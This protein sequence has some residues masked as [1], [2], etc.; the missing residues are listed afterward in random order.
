M[1]IVIMRYMYC[2]ILYALFNRLYKNSISS[3]RRLFCVT[4]RPIVPTLA[5]APLGATY[6]FGLR[7]WHSSGEALFFPREMFWHWGLAVAATTTMP[8]GAPTQLPSIFSPE[9]FYTYTLRIQNYY[10][11]H[12]YDMIL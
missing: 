4:L 3:R 7:L 9:G 1:Q 2:Y 11:Y 6:N 10:Y 12:Y 5:L 8:S